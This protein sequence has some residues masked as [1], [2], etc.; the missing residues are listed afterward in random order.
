MKGQYSIAVAAALLALSASPRA[1]ASV[2]E[3]FT[4]TPSAI[5]SGGSSTLDLT[6]TLSPDG[7]SYFNP[8]FT[9][10]S[11]TF[12]FGDGFTANFSISSGGAFKDITQ[13][14]TYATA[15]NYTASYSFSATYAE[16]YQSYDYLY[17]YS[18]QQFVGYNYYSCGFFSTCS[19]P[20][21]QTVYQPVYGWQ[22]HTAF[23]SDAGSGS[24]NLSVT[25]PVVAAVPEPSTWAMMLLGFAGVGFVAYRRKSKPALLAT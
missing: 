25:D 2:V 9:G 4:V 15:G 19:Y 21:Y 3:N 14:H 8:Q 17:S 11:V 23:N 13:A 6:L 5:A 22:T 10:G 16:Q 24:A 1:E 7:P 20:V 18:Y 12:N